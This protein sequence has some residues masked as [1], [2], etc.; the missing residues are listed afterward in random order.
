M[1]AARLQWNDG[2]LN[3]YSVHHAMVGEKLCSSLL[4]AAKIGW[5]F[6]GLIFSPTMISFIEKMVRRVIV[7][8]IVECALFISISVSLEHLHEF[9]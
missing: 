9:L 7:D 4:Q 5:Q 6:L 1:L 2:T 8:H 3:S